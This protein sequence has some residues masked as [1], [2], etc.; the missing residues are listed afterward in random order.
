MKDIKR[1]GGKPRTVS[2]HKTF[3]AGRTTG[4]A[5][6]VPK[7]SCGAKI[8]E[9]TTKDNEVQGRSGNRRPNPR[10]RGGAKQTRKDQEGGGIGKKRNQAKGGWKGTSKKPLHRLRTG[11]GKHEHKRG[12][13]K[14]R[15]QQQ[16]N[17]KAQG[18]S[19]GG[20]SATT[21]GLN[22]NKGAEQNKNDVGRCLIRRPSLCG[23]GTIN[24]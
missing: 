13:V 21:G 18:N 7:A 15:K 2:E 6:G 12:N 1:K 5:E 10:Q 14:K 11:G 22:S 8:N 20:K 23:L 17:K 19:G 24:P 9:K 4:G 3:R 16:E